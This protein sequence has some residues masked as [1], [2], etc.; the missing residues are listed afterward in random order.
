[1]IMSFTLAL[2]FSFVYIVQYI[3]RYYFCQHEINI[4]N[5]KS[6]CN[7]TNILCYVQYRSIY[8]YKNKHLMVSRNSQNITQSQTQSSKKKNLIAPSFVYYK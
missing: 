4:Y 7:V 5:I 6:I 8:I 1:M 3:I 2:S